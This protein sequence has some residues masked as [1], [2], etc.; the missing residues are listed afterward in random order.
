MSSFAVALHSIP[1]ALT[2]VP[3][4]FLH[5]GNKEHKQTRLEGAQPLC[6]PD[7]AEPALPSFAR[8]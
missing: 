1:D 3:D 8:F 4:S 6:L 7:L 2:S 5:V